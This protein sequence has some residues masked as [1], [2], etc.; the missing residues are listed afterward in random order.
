MYTNM[1]SIT[2]SNLNIIGPFSISLD[3]PKVLGKNRSQWSKKEDFQKMKK[4][5]P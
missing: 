3:C 2:V 1:Y 4:N 5:C